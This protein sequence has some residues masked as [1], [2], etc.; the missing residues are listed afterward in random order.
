[1]IQLFLYFPEDKSEYIPAI[2]TLAVFMIAAVFFMRFIIQ[3]SKRE[4]KKTGTLEEKLENKEAE[5]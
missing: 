3:L 2:I 5:E 1:M 4:E